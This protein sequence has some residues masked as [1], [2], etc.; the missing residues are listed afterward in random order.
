MENKVIDSRTNKEGDI[1]RRACP[2]YLGIQRPAIGKGHTDAGGIL[3]HMVVGKDV[4]LG[5][6][7]EPRAL[8]ALRNRKPETAEPRKG[9]F[10]LYHGG[11]GRLEYRNHHLLVKKRRRRRY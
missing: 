4:A 10:D 11:V 7:K 1:I 8:P 5:V 2:G 6:D 9:Y 3:D